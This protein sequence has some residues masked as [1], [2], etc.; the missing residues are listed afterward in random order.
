MGLNELYSVDI[1]VF[2]TMLLV[3]KYKPAAGLSKHDLNGHLQQMAGANA[4][5]LTTVDQFQNKIIGYDDLK[6]KL[7]YIDLDFDQELLIDIHELFRVKLI[8]KL[9]VYHLELSFNDHSKDPVSI[10][11]YNRFTDGVLTRNRLFTK[12]FY[13]ES[14]L[15]K[16]LATRAE[17]IKKLPKV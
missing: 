14:L 13:W 11:F 15:N 5:T 6:K 1:T 8:K 9:T 16:A 10:I 17:K 2:L 7:I 12:A 4:L 3:W